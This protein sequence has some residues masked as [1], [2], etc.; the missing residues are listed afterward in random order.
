MPLLEPTDWLVP[1]VADDP[2]ASETERVEPVET[3]S[4]TPRAMDWL[5][6]SVSVMPLVTPL[7]TPLVTPAVFVAETESLT[8]EVEPEARD[9]LC[10]TPLES[11]SEVPRAAAV[12][13]D[14][15]K[16]SVRVLLLDTDAPAV[17]V[18][19]LVPPSE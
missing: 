10:P 3:D 4:V 8:P 1:E 12:L 14:V 19:E 5:V 17:V 11:E 16:E 18:V 13:E 9:K 7:D 15:P 2:T 6:P